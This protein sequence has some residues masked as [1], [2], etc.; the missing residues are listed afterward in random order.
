MAMSKV[1]L[2]SLWLIGGICVAQTDNVSVSISTVKRDTTYLYAEA[3]MKDLGDA[4]AAAQAILEV[5][6]GDWIQSAYPSQPIEVCIVKAKEHSFEIHTLRGDYQRAFIYVKK[7]DIILV[8]DQND[9]VVFHVAPVSETT[10]RPSQDMTL[11]EDSPE[12]GIVVNLTVDEQQMRKITSFYDVG[13]YIKNLENNG[14]IK[15]RGKYSTMP[16][17]E[18]CHIFVYDQKGNV[19]A[20][21]RKNEYGQLNLQTMKMD[22]IK[23]YKNCGAIWFQIK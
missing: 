17:E 19:V 1:L 2:I 11:S 14:R 18:P 23:N 12:T 5:K 16:A 10:S 6:V 7:S 13:P 3:T 9:V 21:L 4:S 15:A 22:N 8:S 20:L